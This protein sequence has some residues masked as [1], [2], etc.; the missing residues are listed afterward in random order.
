MSKC[1]IRQ[2]LYGAW[3]VL[4]IRNKIKHEK[5]IKLLKIRN[6][7]PKPKICHTKLNLS[8]IIYECDH[9]LAISK[10]SLNSSN[11]SWKFAISQITKETLCIGL[12]YNQIPKN[13]WI[14]PITL[15]KKGISIRA[16]SPLA[17]ARW[18]Q[19]EMPIAINVSKL[20]EA[21]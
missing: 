10:V 4:Q 20:E 15:H 12:D 7:K 19:Y 18:K 8:R 1:R 2:S 21:I 9:N 14:I 11:S 16:M 3:R 5:N 6:A 13:V 17:S